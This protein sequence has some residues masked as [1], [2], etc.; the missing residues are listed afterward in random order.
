[1]SSTRPLSFSFFG[2]SIM[3]HLEAYSPRLHEPYDL[4]EVGQAVVI[5][6]HRK[7]GWVHALHL[8]LQVA[9][10]SVRFAFDNRGLGGATSRDV[11]RIVKAAA[12]AQPG[13]DVAILGVG[14]NDVWRCFQGRPELA[15]HPREYH[16]NYQ[17]LLEILT[18][19]AQTTICVTET[20]FGWDETLDVAAM[21]SGYLLRLANPAAHLR[22]GVLPVE[23]VAVPATVPT[24][25]GVPQNSTG[26]LVPRR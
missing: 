19:W 2:T 25:P 26:E 3:E 1:M 21:A 10:P 9:W 4:P 6:G 24:R 22:S 18:G 11:L 13:P 8:G 16:D 7:R 17:T 5:E 15:V 23:P 14:I 20:P 12:S